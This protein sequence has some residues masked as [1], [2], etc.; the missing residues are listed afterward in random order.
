MGGAQSVIQVRLL[1]FQGRPYG[2][3]ALNFHT[4]LGSIQTQAVTDSDGWAR[5]ILTSTQETGE[6]VVTVQYSQQVLKTITIIIVDAAEAGIALKA[7]RSNFLASGVDTT[8][9]TISLVS[10]SADIGKDRI[11]SL[12]SSS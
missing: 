3:Q 5:V 2:Q 1:D 7:Y 11:I 10:D 9:I 4:T 8:A 12:T 6:A